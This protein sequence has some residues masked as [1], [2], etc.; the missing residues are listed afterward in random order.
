MVDV[1][2][3]ELFDHHPLAA[4]NARHV[5]RQRIDFESEFRAAPRQG[6]DFRG[7][8]HVFAR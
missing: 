2:L 5:D 3:M 4:L 6:S 1:H 7:V 8:D